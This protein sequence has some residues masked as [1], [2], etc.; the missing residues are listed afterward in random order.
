M[1]RPRDR[2]TA[3][4]QSERG[5]PTRRLTDVHERLAEIPE[6]TRT[7]YM[8]I[9]VTFYVRVLPRSKRSKEWISNTFSH[10]SMMFQTHNITVP[11]S[12]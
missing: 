10:L 5:T 11:I 7:P 1:L 4:G 9:S 6:D 8:V 12:K 3:V 2:V